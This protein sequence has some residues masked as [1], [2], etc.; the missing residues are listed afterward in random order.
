VNIDQIRDKVLALEQRAERLDERQVNIQDRLAILEK[1]QAGIQDIRL[2]IERLTM[3]NDST[4]QAFSDL[5]Q[6]LDRL[7]QK[8]AKRIDE[9]D[10]RLEGHM[11]QPAKRWEDLK[12]VIIVAVV[13]GIVSFTLG[14]ILP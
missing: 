13:T 11:Q 10:E 5:N 8:L 3:G 1:T 2:M 7:D 6:R 4:K 12:W 9:I 14:R